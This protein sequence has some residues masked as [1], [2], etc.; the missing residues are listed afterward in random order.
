MS[1]PSVSFWLASKASK[2][3]TASTISGLVFKPG[4]AVVP[5]VV[6]EGASDR[7][8]KIIPSEDS[9]STLRGGYMGERSVLLLF[10]AFGV[11]V[12][13][14][15]LFLSSNAPASSTPFSP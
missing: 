6:F 15:I 8:P 14:F 3:L 1:D 12:G 10:S 11:L 13:V 9:S 5:S 2:D 7:L 4:V